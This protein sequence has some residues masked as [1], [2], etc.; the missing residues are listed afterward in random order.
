MFDVLREFETDI[1]RCLRCAECHAGCPVYQDDINESYAARG[2]LRLMRAVM[3]GEI[4]LTEGVMERINRCLNC[5]ACMARCP[6]GLDTDM[7]IIRARCEMRDAGIPVPENL[8]AVRA[9][10]AEHRNPFGLPFSERGGWA[11]PEA[12]ERRSD[13]VYFAGCAVSYSQNRMAK[14]ALRLLDGADVEYAALGP[15]ER[16]CGDPVRRMGLEREAEQLVAENREALRARG[17]K[18]VFT[19]CAGCTKTLK[20]TLGDEFEVLH[21]TEL[22][23]RMA[24]EGRI[25]F[26]KAF[27]KKV[28][29]V[30]GCD[31]G[32]HAGVYEAPRD[33]LAR[34]PEVEMLEMPD[35]R[36]KA[37]CCGGP[38]VAAYPE[39]AKKFA[40]ARIETA[41]SIGA[42]VIAVACPTC[43]INL[44]EG[45]K[46]LEGD[47][48]ID[49]QEV[50]TLL[51]RSAKPVKK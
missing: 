23:V 21:V 49:I 48:R 36:D 51:Q 15:D 12:L 33:L 45:A 28:V 3:D 40:L 10:I 38:F 19:S 1:L 47:R 35:N 31:L 22:L 42:E 2:K 11:P 37:I 5:N 16:C 30:D 8:A 44:K 25:A 26:E 39:L 34:L 27:P 32:R 20:S 9:N 29:Y 43:L 13:L 24:N 41:L 46:S 4:E 14:A 6:A 18:T 50:A 17:A 7:L